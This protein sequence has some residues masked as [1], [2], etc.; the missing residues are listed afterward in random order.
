MDH[1][2]YIITYMQGYGKNIQYKTIQ[3]YNINAQYKDHC[4]LQ[5][6]MSIT[7][8]I[9]KFLAT[10]ITDQPYILKTSAN[11]RALLIP[12]ASFH[13]RVSF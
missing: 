2:L 5:M 8:R 1:V 4:A 10:F 3:S 13:M 11:K 12:A 7:F 9:Y 6:P